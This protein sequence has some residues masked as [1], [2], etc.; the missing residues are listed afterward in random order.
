MQL[1]EGFGC[2]QC[3]KSFF[4]YRSLI[5][6]ISLSYP[7]LDKYQ[8]NQSGCNRS[9]NKITNL[10]KH[11]STHHTS[12]S[13]YF[14]DVQVSQNTT[15]TV[16][17]NVNTSLDTQENSKISDHV[18]LNNKIIYF[19]SKLYA[20][21]TLNR[22]VVQEFVLDMKDFLDNIFHHILNK[23]SNTDE[24]FSIVQQ[25][26]EE[27]KKIF[28]NLKSEFLRLKYF[29]SCNT[30]IP[31]TS[32]YIGCQTVLD[33]T[34]TPAKP[35]IKL[36]T[37]SGQKLSIKLKLK[38]FLEIPNVYDDILEFITQECSEN[39]E[40]ISSIVQGQLW[41]QLM[42]NYKNKIFFPLILFYDDFEP[43][44]PLGSRAVIY[45][46][47]AVYI[48]FSCIPPEYASLLENI[49]LT[50]L[51]FTSDKE[52]YGNK[53]VFSNLISDLKSLEDEGIEIVINNEIKKVYFPL[54]LIVGDN[55]GL[56]SV[57]GFS[58]SFSAEYFCRF[59][60]TP[61]NL[62]KVETNSL[63]FISRTPT[64]YKVHCSE[65]TYGVKEMCIWNELKNFHVVKNVYCD[66]MHDIFEGVL[67]YD[68]AFVIDDLIKKKYFD[69]GRLNN[70]IKF[71]KFSKADLGNPPPIIKAEHLKKKYIVMSAS[72]MLSFSIYFGI[73]VGDLVPETESSWTFYLKI[74]E[75]TELMLSRSFT[76]D[77]ISYLKTIIEEHHSLFCELFNESLKPKY[78]LILH[79]PEIILNV[80]PLRNI[81][82]M[83]FEAYHKLLKHTIAT[84]TSHKNILLTISTKDSLRFSHRILSRKGFEK[85]FDFRAVD[86]N[87]GDLKDLYSL[88]EKFSDD[89]FC[90]SW[91]IINDYFY[92]GEFLI[93]ISKDDGI[94]P[95]F[96]QIKYIILDNK[97][98]F[99]LVA[100]ITYIRYLNH[101]CAYEVEC[102]KN[103]Q[104]LH[105]HP[106]ESNYPQ[107]YSVHYTGNGKSVVL[108]L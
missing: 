3:N 15:K 65:L 107:P 78:H 21:Q 14:L 51:F 10:K 48:S 35:G 59:C 81:W 71:L 99:F 13:N 45:K 42:I 75:M 56:N 73:L 108:K 70:R 49:F 63:N 87:L 19:I 103:N 32:F 62:T 86:T 31:A 5:R 74:R 104:I 91:I 102:P 85:R 4:Y 25:E 28:E 92:T 58:E 54:I 27:M 88:S 60:I 29:K 95:E 34:S 52:F 16:S 89:A 83:K 38:M 40:V 105:L 18:D 6:H 100:K 97:N 72:E 64:N 36:K 50:Q 2:F 55:L 24:C 30:F 76:I 43:C 77:R 57:L 80:G 47:G 11:Y 39:N 12:S 84:T 82:C 7:Y 101:I 68:M 69:L 22:K 37:D 41:K 106:Y 53:K 61:R 66:L 94:M 44:N 93:D 20:N 79:Y 46:V 17:V 33:N 23:I 9:F 98:V 8:C 90:V 1:N 26:S 96:G 67:R